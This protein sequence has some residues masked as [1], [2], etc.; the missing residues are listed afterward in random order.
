MGKKNANKHYKFFITQNNYSEAQYNLGAKMIKECEYGIIC[1]E[2][3]TVNKVPHIHIWLHYKAERSWKKMQREWPQ[4]NVQPGLGHD[5]DQTYLKKDGNY[6][7]HGEP[8][9]GKGK[10]T[11]LDMIK[12]IIK[13]G[14][15]MSE[16]IDVSSNFQS[17]KMGELLFKYR[18]RKRAV[19]PIEVYWFYGGAGSGKTK[20]V[21]DAE[22]DI[23]RPTSKKWWEGYDG[24][25]VV[26]IDDWRPSWCSY[27]ELLKFTDIYPFKVETKGGSREVKYDKLYITSDRSPYDYYVKDGI[28]DKE[29]YKQ[30]ERR[31]TNVKQFGV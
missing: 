26:L 10:R 17:L 11:D 7:E 16:I 31:I 24:D 22:D 19:K 8:Q 27:V 13:N 20:F 29:E 3:G 9:K 18:E 12:K 30:L 15:T 4:A 23:F 5:Q 28:M 2:I 14:G 25:R 6:E 21:F 1:R